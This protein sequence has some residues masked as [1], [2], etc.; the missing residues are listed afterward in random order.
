MKKSTLAVVASGI[1]LLILLFLT[2]N[3]I[4]RKTKKATGTKIE[5]T[6]TV[7]FFV[8]KVVG[9]IKT[10]AKTGASVDQVLVDVIASPCQWAGVSP[11]LLPLQRGDVVLVRLTVFGHVTG[12]TPN[13]SGEDSTTWFRKGYL[14]VTEKLDS[15]AVI[16]EKIPVIQYEV[17]PATALTSGQ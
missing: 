8:A 14:V 10:K 12:R 6:V 5:D 13:P 11:T 7:S 3:V 9:P 1:M 15:T 4:V 17:P 2:V 16:S